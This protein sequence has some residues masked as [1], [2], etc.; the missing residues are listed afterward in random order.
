MASNFITNGVDVKSKYSVGEEI[1]RG[2]YGVIMQGID[3]DTGERVAMLFLSLSLQMFKDS[4]SG[5]D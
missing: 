5:C 2:V 3:H 4:L 1:G